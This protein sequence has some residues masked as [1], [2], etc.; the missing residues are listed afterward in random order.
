MKKIALLFT[1]IVLMMIPV[2]KGQAPFSRGVNLTE[3]FQTTSAQSIQF[4]KYTKKDFSNIKSLG[5][6]V[7]RLPINLFYMTSGSPDYTLDPLFYDFLDQAVSWAEELHV[8]LILDNHSTDDIASKNPNL[9]TALTKV[10]TQM[11]SHY[12]DC[13]SYILYEVLN[14]PNGL[15]T[16][17]WGAIQQKAITAIRSV[18]ATHTIVVGSSGWNTYNELNQLPYYTDANLLYTFHFYDPFVFTHQGASWSSPSMTSLANV[19]FPYNAS[20]MPAVPSDLAGTWVA[21]SLANY[22]NEGTVAKIR[23]LIDVAVA[24]KTSRNL[25]LYCGEF[26]VYKP[27]SNNTDRAYWY[28]QVG[29]YL[30]SKG[31]AWTTWDYQGGFGLFNKGSNE[32]FDYD[33]NV[34]V[35]NALGL[36]V[37]PQQVYTLK[38]D[39]VGFDIYTDYIGEKMIENDSKNGAVIDFYSAGKPNNGKYCLSWI[40]SSQY[41]SVGVDFEPDKDLSKLKT[42]NYALSMLVRGNTPGTKFDLRFTDTK[43]NA[44]D[45]PWRMNYTVDDTK[46]TWD[47]KWHKL[48][49]PLTSFV[50]GGSWDNVW[51]NPV[52]AFDWSATDRF[53]IVAEQMS[54]AGK[55]LWFDNIQISNVDSAQVNE[56]SIFTDIKKTETGNFLLKVFPNPVQYSTAI[57]YTLTDNA[58][59]DVAIYTL[60]GQKVKTLLSAKQSPG[61]YQL[62]WNI[63]S[64]NGSRPNKGIY[65]CRLLVSGQI[66]VT[67]IIVL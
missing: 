2:V 42:Q 46:V 9:E 23:S 47:G 12:K 25:N 32:Q 31:I 45:H 67:K 51:F 11:A 59:V 64:D 50:E 30:Q 17:T 1:G 6:D 36:N 61:N 62:T 10:W 54:M 28:G 19:P 63:D 60:N 41:G 39:S 55:S 33:L 26:G 35:L 18:D 7:I 20:A 8:Y 49:I 22:S 34:P 58:K 27:N 14:E 24:F 48:F 38:P 57:S 13:S 44:S 66:T 5:C 53:E 65:F 21:G 43:K 40:G 29:S 4:S 3:W 37:P 15:T 56:P 16:A 52:G